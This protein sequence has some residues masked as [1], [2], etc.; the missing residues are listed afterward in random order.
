LATLDDLVEQVKKDLAIDREDLSFSAAQNP[1]LHEKYLRLLLEYKNK[2]IR[3]EATVNVVTRELREFYSG[4]APPDVYKKRPF[5]LK[6]LKNELPIYIESDEEYV[7]AITK[8]NQ[9]QSIVSYLEGVVNAV[10][11]R[12]YDIKNV[13]EWEKFKNGGY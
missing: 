13:I 12:G 5:N 11:S 1:I 6:L 9:L 8:F 10:K 7:A 2:L 4:V 3:V